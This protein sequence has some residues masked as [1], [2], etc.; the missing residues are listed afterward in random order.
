MTYNVHHCNPPDARNLIDVGAVA[1]VIN[2]AHPDFVALQEIDVHTGRSGKDLDQARELARLTG[3]YSFFAKAIDYQGGDYG[4]AILS[5]YPIVDS[6]AFAL[7]MKVGSGGEPRALAVITVELKRGR[8]IKFAGTHLDLK[9]ENRMLQVQ[10]IQDLF[11]EEKLPIVLSGDFNA[12]PGSEPINFMDQFFK[13]SCADNCAFTDPAVNPEKAIDFIMFTPS[14]FKVKSHQVI[15]KTYASDH[16]P[17]LAE[18][19]L[20]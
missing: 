2:A 18:L 17:V 1:R 9:P 10:K 15:T 20:N 13:R 3:M 11:K 7:P 5:R 19:K 12:T 8:K 6:A 4:I 14:K 16:L